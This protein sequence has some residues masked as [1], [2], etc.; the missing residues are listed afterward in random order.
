MSRPCRSPACPATVVPFDT[1]SA[2]ARVAVCRHPQLLLLLRLLLLLSL[3]SPPVVRCQVA[4]VGVL[5][6]Y[7]VT[8]RLGQCYVRQR[9]LTSVCHSVLSSFLVALPL[10]LS[11]Q[12]KARTQCRPASSI[13]EQ[14]ELCPSRIRATA[15]CF[16]PSSD[17]LFTVHIAWLRV[18]VRLRHRVRQ[19]GGHVQQRLPRPGLETEHHRAAVRRQA[20]V[21]RVPGGNTA[22]HTTAPQARHTPLQ[23]RTDPVRCVYCVCSRLVRSSAALPSAAG[24]RGPPR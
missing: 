8:T 3:L 21:R 7:D 20:S 10:F 11:P 23:Q 6:S 12:V 15:H 17:L 9:Q 1:Q 18:T 22:W 16:H 14:V 4:I 24:T 5:P 2:A 19:P 13:S